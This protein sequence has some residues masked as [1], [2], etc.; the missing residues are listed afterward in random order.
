[1]IN[2]GNIYQQHEGDFMEG[3]TVYVLPGGYQS[4]FARSSQRE[5]KNIIA[6]IRE[7]TLETLQNTGIEPSRIDSIHLGNFEAGQYTGQGHLNALPQEA[8]HD[9]VGKPAFRYEAACASGGT[10]ILGAIKDIRAGDSDC[11]LLLGVEQMKLV[12]PQEGGNYLGA[13]ANWEEEAKGVQFPFPK[14]FGR[15]G[16]EYM[17]LFKIPK[18]QYADDQATLAEMMYRNARD[19]PLAQTRDWSMDRQHAR[20]ED[21]KLNSRIYSF[22]S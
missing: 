18:E 16:A 3:P 8:H 5:G 22:F 7:C 15:L 4:D 21:T 19:N 2:Q 14:L 6:M 11:V 10:A 13:A 12:S 17:T 1:M 9:L 20:H